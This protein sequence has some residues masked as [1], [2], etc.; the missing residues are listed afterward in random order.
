MRLMRLLTALAMAWPAAAADWSVARSEHFEV[1]SDAGAETTR[2]LDS[3]LERLHTFFVRQ[4]GVSPRGT[5]RVIC[6]ATQQD[7][8]DYRISPNAAGYSLTTPERQYIVMSGAGKP[9]LGVPA[10][11]Y[12]HLLIHSSGWKL[13]EWL[14]E[15]ISEVVS[16]VQVGE[17]YSFIGGDLPSRSHVLK[18]AQWMSPAELFATRNPSREP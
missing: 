11:E 14:A 13:P 5:V 8:A 3:G 9:N 15:G 1:W 17:R 2:H 18:S 4:I 12:A 16:S 6:F 7:F 10:H